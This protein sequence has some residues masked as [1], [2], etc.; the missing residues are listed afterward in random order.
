M[1]MHERDML[2]CLSRAQDSL[3]ITTKLLSYC[4]DHEK[5]EYIQNVLVLIQRE[6]LDINIRLGGILR[7]PHDI[8]VNAHHIKKIKKK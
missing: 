3:S 2:L 8:A 7:D 5:K 4:S 6:L 1:D